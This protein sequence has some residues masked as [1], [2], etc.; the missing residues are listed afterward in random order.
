[1]TYNIENNQTLK[2]LAVWAEDFV[3]FGSITEARE[4]ETTIFHDWIASEDAHD[5]EERQMAVYLHRKWNELFDLLEHASQDNLA[6][7][8]KLAHKAL[9]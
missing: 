6:A 3:S 1:M 9:S 8:T 4:I 2:S 7:I 5:G